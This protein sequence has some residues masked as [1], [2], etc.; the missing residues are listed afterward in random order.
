MFNYNNNDY[1]NCNYL[2]R[3]NHMNMDIYNMPNMLN[4]YNLNP[5]TVNNFPTVFNIEKMAMNN[6]NFQDEIWKGK[7]LQVYL[8]HINP[9]ESLGIRMYD[10]QDQFIHTVEGQGLCLMGD[11]KTNLS[12]KNIITNG[13]CAIIPAETYYDIVNTGAI[14][15][16]CFTVFAPPSKEEESN[17]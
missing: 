14:A 2:N 5:N 4:M 1:S 11:K 12:Y 17:N 16:K 3:T 8:F 10:N 13:S 6:M 9:G 15:L 7:Y